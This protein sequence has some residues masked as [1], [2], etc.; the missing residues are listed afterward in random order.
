MYSLMLCTYY[1]RLYP[2]LTKVQI[3]EG[4]FFV[5]LG[6]EI[7]ALFKSPEKYNFPHIAQDYSYQMENTIILK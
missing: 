7:V 2:I 3:I 4:T 1:L 6:V 5:A